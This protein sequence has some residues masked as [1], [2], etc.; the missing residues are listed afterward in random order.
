[1][2]VKVGSILS[3]PVPSPGDAKPKEGVW[4]ITPGLPEDDVSIHILRITSP[5]RLPNS[6][7]AK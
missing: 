4:D 2:N 6:Q 5:F 7:N 1:M 3:P